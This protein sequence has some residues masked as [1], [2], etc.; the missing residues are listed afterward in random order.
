MAR[1][2]FMKNKWYPRP[3]HKNNTFGFGLESGV[4]NRATIYPVIM[5]DEGL[6][7]PATYNAHPEHASFALASEPNCYPESR[8]N[9]VVVDMKFNLTKD[10]LETDKLSHVRVATMPITV[11]FDDTEVTD[12]LS[13]SSIGDILHLQRETTDRQTYPLWNGVDMKDYVSANSANLPTNVPGLTTD[14]SIEGIDWNPDVFYNGIQYYTTANKLKSVQRGLK[15]FNLSKNHPTARVRFVIS[16]KVKRINPYTF[17]G[18]LAYVPQASSPHQ[19]HTTSDTTDV[20]HVNCSVQYRYQEWN[21]G[22]DMDKV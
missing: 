8:V 10:F 14:Q 1:S 22:F 9:S 18:V 12:E 5:H 13:G 20:N 7:N 2:M 16:S 11:A 6:G 21:Q 3:H 17:F 15:W 19:Y 4:E